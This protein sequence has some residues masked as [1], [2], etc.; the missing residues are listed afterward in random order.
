M[1]DEQRPFIG[2]RSAGR[3]RPEL[4]DRRAAADAPL[5]ALRGFASGVLGAP[6]DIESFVRMLPGLSEETVLPT[7]EDVERRLPGRAISQ[8]SPTGRAF[9]GAAQLAG[10]FYGGPGSPLRL[11]AGAPGAV[12]KAGRDFVMA[13]GQPPVNVVKPRGGNWLAGTVERTLEPLKVREPTQESWRQMM[14]ALDVPEEDM[15]ARIAEAR[16]KAPASALNDWVEQKLG[17]YLRNELA[18]PVDSLRT[19]ASRGVHPLP[20]EDLMMAEGWVPEEVISRRKAAGFPEEGVSLEPLQSATAPLSEEQFASMR[21]AAGWEN[22]ADSMV[23]NPTVEQLLKKYGGVPE[24]MRQN[25]WLKDLPPGTRVH[26]ITGGAGDM[27]LDVITQGLREMLAAGEN[28]PRNMRLK[29]EDLKKTS[30]PQ[31]IEKLD[32]YKAWLDEQAELANPAIQVFKEYPEAGMRWVELKMPKGVGAEDLPDVNDK[33]F[34]Q[35]LGQEGY[36]LD[37]PGAMDEARATY[38]LRQRGATPDEP[39]NLDALERALK[40]EGDL[41]GNC[42]G[43]YCEDVALGSTRIFSLRDKKGQPQVTIEVRPGGKK[44]VAEGSEEELRRAAENESW[45][46][47]DAG[48]ARSIEAIYDEVYARLKPEFASYGD[49]ADEII[50]IKGSGKKDTMQRLRHK[51]TGYADEPDA[52]LLPFVHDFVK[53][54]KWS[55]VQDLDNAALIPLDPASDLGQ[56]MKAAGVDVPRYVTQDELT[57]L[58]EQYGRTTLPSAPASPRQP[59]EMPDL[60]PD[61]EPPRPQGRADEGPDFIPF[62]RGGSVNTSAPGTD[63]YD[64]ATIDALAQKLSEEIYG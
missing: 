60:F 27:G 61:W 4:N 29:P 31:A 22:I 16:S 58:L 21:R 28:L 63:S 45:A 35:W 19:L 14:R 59:G 34:Q 36:D 13:A 47:K 30:L 26:E 5:S 53:S 56:R 15:P 18:T 62:A 54:G 55:R 46:L 40:R 1:A 11:I 64:P 41:M 10:G 17:N 20:S 32:S 49:E 6:G 39:G 38:A 24:L 12:R 48:D 23:D 44:I 25:P 37:V 8:A 3:R 42:V 43:D 33:K 51:G 2:Y 57:P 50:Q 52:A 9:T 7:S